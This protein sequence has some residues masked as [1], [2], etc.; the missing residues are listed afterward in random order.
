MQLVNSEQICLLMARE[1]FDIVHLNPDICPHSK[2][3]MDSIITA[4]D[5]AQCNQF[6]TGYY[7]ADSLSPKT[8]KKNLVSKCGMTQGYTKFRPQHQPSSGPLRLINRIHSFSQLLP[9][10]EWRWGSSHSAREMGN[11]RTIGIFSKVP[12]EPF[13]KSK[14][15][16][17]GWAEYGSNPVDSCGVWQMCGGILKP[18]VDQWSGVQENSPHMQ[19]NQSI[20]LV[21]MW[22]FFFPE[23]KTEKSFIDK[24]GGSDI[25]I[26]CA[27]AQEQVLP[28][29]KNQGRADGFKLWIH[30]WKL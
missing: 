24:W 6:C 18:D 13:R 14:V 28:A 26:F 7:Q 23:N 25:L 11:K 9:A 22:I 3:C 27:A 21:S 8:N 20:N 19:P 17:E 16:L 1:N 4:K 12:M 15:I 5:T 2:V 30:T 10:R 29:F